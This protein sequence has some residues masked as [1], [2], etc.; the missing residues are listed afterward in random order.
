MLAPALVWPVVIEMADVL[1]KNSVDVSRVVNRN[2]V[3]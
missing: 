3:A 2:P 1:I